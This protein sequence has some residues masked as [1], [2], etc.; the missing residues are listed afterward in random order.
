MNMIQEEE[1]QQYV[2]K[3]SRTGV[4]EVFDRNSTQKIIT[5][6]NRASSQNMFEG[7]IRTSY[8]NGIIVLDSNQ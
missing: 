7:H 2:D 5:I 1:Q 3:M 6:N 4:K 8:N